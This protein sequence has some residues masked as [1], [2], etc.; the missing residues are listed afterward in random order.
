MT[1]QVR[2][3]IDHAGKF[4]VEHVG[5]IPHFNQPVNLDA[6]RTGVVHTT[7]GSTIEG[8]MG[9]FRQHFAP[10]FLLGKSASGGVKILQLVQ[11]G[12]IGA[13]L[14]THND[15]AIVQV[16]VA[17][18]S[19]TSP[20]LPDDDTLDALASLM[21]VCQQ[22]YGIPLAHPWVDGDFGR[23]GNNPHRG[24]G[25][26]G[27]VAGWYGHGDVPLPDSHWDPGALEWSKVFARAEAM[28]GI[29]GAPAWAPS[30]EPPR[31][32]ACGLDSHG[33]A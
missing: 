1:I 3:W 18:F 30:P 4:A 24:A 31:L 33:A 5:G 19:K 7:E 6:P 2:P 9:V 16:E 28:T 29:A 20:W 21:A 22:E 32:C 25:K 10:H 27:V 11:V 14:V 26:W 15:H 17:G 13:A 23:A 12:T 8:A